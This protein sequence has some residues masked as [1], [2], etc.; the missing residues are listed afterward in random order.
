MCTGC[1]VR[2]P[3]KDLMRIV[4]IK[5]NDEFY[6]KLDKGQKSAGRGA[7]LCYDESCLKKL[8][9]M[10]PKGKGFL[11]NMD[12]SLSEEIEKTIENV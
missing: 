10:K 3:K 7:Y 12:E 8:K 4:K 11:S 6:I 9:K 1:R 2:K 5:D